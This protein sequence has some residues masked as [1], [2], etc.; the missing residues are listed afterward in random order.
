MLIVGR[1]FGCSGRQL[2]YVAP[3]INN[4][5]DFGGNDLFRAIKANFR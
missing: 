5:E 2:D 1:N 4:L 3:G